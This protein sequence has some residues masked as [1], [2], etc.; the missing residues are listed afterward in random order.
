MIVFRLQKLILL[1]FESGFS[2]GKLLI[3]VSRSNLKLELSFFLSCTSVGD[4]RVVDLCCT[5]KIMLCI[6]QSKR[7]CVVAICRE[8]EKEHTLTFLRE[9]SLEIA[10]FGFSMEGKHVGKSKS[11]ETC[12][13]CHAFILDCAKV[14]RHKPGQA[15]YAYVLLHSPTEYAT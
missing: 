14:T 6:L 2:S 12:F 1:R 5:M 10:D 13:Q 9:Y 7:M 15:I 3:P 11:R 4:V 8:E